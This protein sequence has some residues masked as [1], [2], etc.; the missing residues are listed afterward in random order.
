[1][2]ARGLA[3]VVLVA[4]PASA[5]A[6]EV[7]EVEGAAPET[8][9]PGE[10][11]LDADELMAMPGADND[12]LLALQ[13]LPG[14]ARPPFGMGGLIVRGVSPSNTGV[15]L[16]GMEVP[17]A[18]H[19]LGVTSFLPSSMVERVAVYPSAATVEYGGVL[20]GVVDI[21]RREARRD[22]WRVGG[23]VALLDAAAL[24]EGPVAGGGLIVGVRRSYVDAILT[25]AGRDDLLRP[26]YLDAQI[27]YDRGEP[28][29][30]TGA[31]S[32][33]LIASD[34]DVVGETE[35]GLG[36]VRG[37][38]AWDR[39]VGRNAQLHL[40]T[41]VGRDRAV[42]YNEPGPDRMEDDVALNTRFAIPMGLRAQLSGWRGRHD[43]R[44]G[45]D[46][47]GGKFGP[48]RTLRVDYHP[49]IEAY[50]EFVLPA[51][52]STD[53]GAWCDAVL[54]VDDRITVRPGLRVDRF[55]HHGEWTL[56]P[57]VTVSERVDRQLTLRQSIAIQH[58]PPSPADL[59]WGD[60][61]DQ[62]R[63]MWAMH[64]AIGA[65]LALTPATWLRAGAYRIEGYRLPVATGY[66]GP[67]QDEADRWGKLTAELGNALDE[68]LAAQLGSFGNRE[69][70]GRMWNT[71][72]EIDARHRGARA[73]VW[74]AYT[75]SQARRGIDASYFEPSD[76]EPYVLD[77]AHTLALAASVPHGPWRFGARLAAASGRRSPERTVVELDD[78]HGFYTYTRQPPVATLD[79]R[80]DRSWKRRH[81]T[82]RAYLEIRNAT[83]HR[84][85]EGPTTPGLPILPFVGVGF[86]P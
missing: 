9:E 58:Q 56:D 43:W 51:E 45:I 2:L 38:I 54:R 72:V 26:S 65:E 41:W 30:R 20:G 86:D 83:N 23:E 59:Q 5:V 66:D 52:W 85:L 15:Y 69:S 42:V 8:A 36:F 46:A 55:D 64:A 37:R 18:F 35:A 50:K 76:R 77:Q 53:L 27:A 13:S 57:R 62:L 61:Q 49:V 29:D 70:T 67:G 31:W 32:A 44:I 81:G 47:E 33:M 71:G 25:A 22:R 10:R 80:I 7:I 74:L 1:M 40:A 78:N 19:F 4:A 24:A 16:D 6:D 48:T 3:L 39:Q 84:N 14:F 60:G 21:Q 63:S 79:L 73:D 68:L 28:A 34:D 82:I 75:W 11:D 17:L 12:V